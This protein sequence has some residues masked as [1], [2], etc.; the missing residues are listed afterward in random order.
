MTQNHRAAVF[1]VDKLGEED[2]ER[3]ADWV[4][5]EVPRVLAE[6]EEGKGD[7]EGDGGKGRLQTDD[8]A[9]I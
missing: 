2:V 4:E 5:G 1:R 7:R 9:W 3:R 6:R 8:S